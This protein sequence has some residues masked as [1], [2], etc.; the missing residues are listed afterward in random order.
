MKIGLVKEYLLPSMRI[1]VK[2]LIQNAAVKFKEL[3]AQVEE[4]S[5]MD[6]KYAIGVYTVIQRSEVSSNLARFDGIRYGNGREL[7]GDEAKRRIMLGTF[8]L[9]AG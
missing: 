6:P 9:S 3:G 8:T 4:I 1:E 7:F 5:L 2:N